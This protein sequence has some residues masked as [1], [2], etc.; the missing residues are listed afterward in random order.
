M[1]LLL[2]SCESTQSKEFA[3][4]ISELSYDSTITHNGDDEVICL[5]YFNGMANG[6]Y[7]VKNKENV[8][9]ELGLHFND[10]IIGLAEYRYSDCIEFKSYYYF[11]NSENGRNDFLMSEKVRIDYENKIDSV[12]SFYLNFGN[13]LLYKVTMDS[14]VL[15]VK[16]SIGFES[17]DSLGYKD[18]RKINVVA[19]G[20]LNKAQIRLNKLKPGFNKRIV[21]FDA[22]KY[23]KDGSFKYRTF[24]KEFLIFRDLDLNRNTK[25]FN[26]LKLLEKSENSNVLHTIL[27]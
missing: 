18:D 9:K 19:I 1:I 12:N 20:E 4:D 10:T 21:T 5:N 17:Y 11:Y 16:S 3:E 14:I 6:P 24:R 23:L 26:L 25:S 2:I 13:N 15:E 7:I 27:K 22:L 8:V